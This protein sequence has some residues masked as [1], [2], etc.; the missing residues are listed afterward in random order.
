MKQYIIFYNGKYLN[1]NKKFI[2]QIKPGVLDACGVFETMA[3]YDGKIF[4]IDKHWQRLQRGLG[5]Y[6][7]KSPYS[8]KKLT[9]SCYQVIKR[10]KISHGRI[11][12]A[13]YRQEKIITSIVATPAKK[14][15]KHDY[16]KGYKAYV[17]SIVR[18]PNK[19][20]H[21]K[22]HRYSLFY[23]ALLEARAHKC[24]EAILLNKHK[25]IV[26]GAMTNVFFIKGNILMTPLIACGCLNGIT[27]NMVIDI[28]G[29][30]GLKVKKGRYTLNSLKNADEAFVTNSILPVMALTSIGG[31]KVG[32]RKMGPHTTRILKAY[33]RHSAATEK[34]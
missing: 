23:R 7:I 8:L 29:A 3:I 11:R 22:G 12:V 4:A 16:Q 17:S 13:I 33:L 27:R 1:V 34:I 24:D 6:Q 30:L 2:D 19:T 14:K 15:T 26:E 25:E 5:A 21:V 32:N 20:S 31:V 9:E 28:A 18:N 10:N